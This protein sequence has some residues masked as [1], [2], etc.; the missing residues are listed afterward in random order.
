MLI[1]NIY[2]HT[3]L[4]IYKEGRTQEYIARVF[5]KNQSRIAQIIG[6]NKS[7]KLLAANKI[8]LLSVNEF[9]E[10]KKQNEIAKDINATEGRVSQILTEFK[11]IL[12]LHLQNYTQEEIAERI[13]LERTKITRKLKE[14]EENTD[15]WSVG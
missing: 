10:G 12:S 8:K 15:T 3:G 11:N 6:G 7:L 14:I 5:G 13:G 4:L 1:I 2:L 9:L